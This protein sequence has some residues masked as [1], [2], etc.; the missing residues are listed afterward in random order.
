MTKQHTPSFRSAALLIGLALVL[1]TAGTAG[2]ERV[3]LD[4]QPSDLVKDQWVWAPEESPTGPIVVVVSLNEQLAYVYRNGIRIGYTNVATGRKGYETPTG[5][6]TVLEK[7]VHHVS[8]IYNAKMPYTERLTWGGIS[9][10]AGGLPGYPS[11]HGCI[12]LPLDFAHLLFDA[13]SMGTTVVIANDHEGPEEASHPGFVLSPLPL[14]DDDQT[15]PVLGTDAYSWQPD[16]APDGPLSLLVSAADKKIYVYRAGIEIG[17]AH[18]RIADPEIP[19][20]EGVFSVLVGQGDLDDPW[21][22]GKP[23]HRWLNVHGGGA[24][25]A[26]TQEQAVNRIHIPI[27]FA[28]VI[29][30]MIEPGTTLVITNYAAAPHTKSEDGFI[31]VAAQKNKAK[32]I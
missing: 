28:A 14:E 1:G 9:L 27:Y 30:E 29:Y 32:G 31:V 10:H 22:P 6:F 4:V 17:V 2:A 13:D 8:S 26:E 11:S 23:A 19:I 18:I 21:L 7:S 12:H 15:K 24:V 5:I 20:G 25:D 16:R 3:G